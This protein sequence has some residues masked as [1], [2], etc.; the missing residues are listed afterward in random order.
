MTVCIAAICEPIVGEEYVI[1]ASDRMVSMG[2]YFSGDDVVQKAD[3]VGYGWT[4]MIAGNDVSPAVPILAKIKELNLSTNNEENLVNMT[5][6]FK[7]AF[8]KQRLDEIEDEILS[9]MGFTWETFRRDARNQLPDAAFDRVVEKIRTFELDL[10]FLVS[11]FDAKGAGHIFTVSNP[12][13]CD[14]YDKLG[15]WA[16]GSGQHQ[17]LASMFACEYFR[18]D[19]LEDCVAKVLSSKLAAESATGVGKNTWALV[20]SAKIPAY[21][22]HIMPDTLAHFRMEWEKL[23]RVP[24]NTFM[25]IHEN[26]EKERQRI[27]EKVAQISPPQAG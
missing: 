17:A 7:A 8:R 19:P 16:I 23:E 25:V 21:S 5:G 2:G 15:F 3:P 11:G 6:V 22:M 9:P 20:G 24:R 26:L 12:G 4:S 14:Y 10:S 27:E 1:I 18:H 13:K